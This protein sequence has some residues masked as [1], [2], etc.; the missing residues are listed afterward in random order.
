MFA[1]PSLTRDEVREIDRR[2]LEEY[3]LPGLV[4]MENAGR[5]CADLLLRLGVKGPVCVCCGK[6]NNAGDG[7][8]IARHLEAVGAAVAVLL[9]T[10]P[11]GLTGDALANFRVLEQAETPVLIQP[12]NGQLGSHLAR[13]EWI[14]DALLGTG[15]QGEVRPPLSQVI[16]RINAAG[17]RVLAVDLPSG[18]DCDTGVPLGVCV[19]ADQTATF[20]AVKRG[21][22][23]PEASSWVGG[24]H[25]LSIG[26]PRRLLAAYNVGE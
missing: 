5:G 17:K 9:F 10:E 18:L 2:A 22:Q 6:G 13:S 14:V 8:V 20:V 12:T 21:F 24:V 16:D 19:R 23:S 11:A 7:F 15:L 3:G 25:V 1:S 4:L 26:V